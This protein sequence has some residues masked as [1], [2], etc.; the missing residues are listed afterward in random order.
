MSECCTRSPS[1]DAFFASTK[2]MPVLSRE[3]INDLARKKDAGDID[4]RNKIVEHNARLVWVIMKQRNMV[5]LSPEKLED[6]YAA[7]LAGLIDA[8]DR[9][10]WT[11]GFTFG[12][13][14]RFCIRQRMYMEISSQQTP[15]TV[16][17][18]QYQAAHAGRSPAHID[19]AV[20]A[21]KN[22][23]RSLDAELD[24]GSEFSHL[25]GDDNALAMFHDF[26]DR[27]EGEWLDLLIS[28]LPPREGRVVRRYYYDGATLD[29]IANEIELTRERVRQIKAQALGRLYRAVTG[30]PVPIRSTAG[31]EIGAPVYGSKSHYGYRGTVAG[32]RI[33]DGRT[34]VTICREGGDYVSLPIYDVHRADRDNSRGGILE[35]ATASGG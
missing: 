8:A 17:W 29:K 10:D 24:E 11:R 12:S 15:L 26:E 22:M 3:E 34:M 31:L 16:P 20:K 27:E 1:L 21:A 28:D 35:M 19:R 32:F 30:R 7:G 18:N 6:V 25:I 33:H 4:A 9:Y 5:P 23:G 14:A 2:R 13:W